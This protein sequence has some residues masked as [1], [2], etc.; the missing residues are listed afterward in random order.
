VI[1]GKPERIRRVGTVMLYQFVAGARVSIYCHAFK[2]RWARQ[3][4]SIL[5]PVLELVP[6][7]RGEYIEF[8]GLENRV[9]SQ[10]H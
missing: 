7:H 8:W 1:A 9:E 5:S 2:Y 4:D 6:Y 3:L 10:V